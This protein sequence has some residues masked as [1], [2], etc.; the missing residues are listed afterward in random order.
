MVNAPSVDVEDWFHMLE[1]ES[2]PDV[3]RWS[4]LES[5]IE[6]NFHVLLDTFDQED[7]KVTCFFL[8][9]AAERFPHLIR[10]AARRGHEFAYHRYAHQLFYTQ[11]RDEFAGGIRRA[12]RILE[13]LTGFT[14]EGYRA[15]SFSITAATPWVFEKLRTAGFH[16]DPS[17]LPAVPGHSGIENAELRPHVITTQ[18]GPIIAFSISVALIMSR[19]K[20]FF[21]GCYLQPFP[22]PILHRMTRA[23]N[24]HG[25]SVIFY[26]HPREIDPSHPRLPVGLVRRFKSYV[27]LR[28]ALTKLKR[29]LKDQRL[30]TFGEW[31]PKN[32]RELKSAAAS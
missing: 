30:D 19:Q 20:C 14:V 2:T 31:L 24:D 7:I 27:N 26:V 5:R 18:T 17:V 16:Y 25:R 11:S 1:L 12:K 32:G 3:G 29:P 21:R 9:W 13:D 15:P 22:Y 23:V 4:S 8:G 6:R 28:S 10:E